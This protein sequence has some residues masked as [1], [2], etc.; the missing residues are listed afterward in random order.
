MK[1]SPDAGANSYDAIVVGSRHQRRLGRQGAVERGLR[2][3]VL[4][5]GRPSIPAT[6][7]RRAHAS[8]GRCK[9][10]GLG[11]PQALRARPADPEQAATPATSRASKFFVNDR[12]QSLHVRP[13]TSRSTG[14][15]AVR[16]A[17]GRIM[18]GRQVYRWSDLDFEANARDGIAV[19]WP[20][21]YADIAPWY[22][23][24]ERFIGVSGR[25]E[26]LAQ[27]PDGQFLPPMEMN[28][29]ERQVRDDARGTFGRRAAADDRPR[30][31][32]SPGTTTAGRPATTAAP[33]SA[34]AS[35]ARTSAAS[36]STL[37]AARRDRPA[38]LRPDSVVH[39][40]IYDPS[41]AT[42]RRGVRVIDAETMQPLEFRARV[43]FLCASALESARILLNSTT[44]RFPDRPGQLERR[45]GPQ[46]HGPHHG[47]R[48]ERHDRRAWTTRARSA[49]G[50][51]AS[52]SRGSGT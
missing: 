17:A 1:G 50:R 47:R 45:A 33:A 39:S 42:G 30:A 37:P 9:F 36:A 20:I 18:W 38:T 32:S 26:G 49:G 11:R 52:T 6:R 34:A 4:E 15:G 19:D 12:R 14:S 29:A 28:C 35:P 43:V 7:L 21:R 22:D 48:R 16:S 5:A 46:P 23:H 31:R 24:V 27:L 51:T 8:P 3:L 10:R 25:G 40:V 41:D 2:T 44:P 13:A